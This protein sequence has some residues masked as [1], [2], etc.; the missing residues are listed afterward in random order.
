MEAQIWA[1]YFEDMVGAAQGFIVCSSLPVT[2]LR[3][4][5]VLAHAQMLAQA[6]PHYRAKVGE[7]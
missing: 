1:C 2:W 5:R 4:L 6:R 7:S 3:S